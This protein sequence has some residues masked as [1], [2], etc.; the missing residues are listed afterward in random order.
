MNIIKGD[1]NEEIKNINTDSIDLIY[2]NPPFNTTENEWDIALNWK[3]LLKICGE[4]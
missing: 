1:I 3:V 4:F 2:T